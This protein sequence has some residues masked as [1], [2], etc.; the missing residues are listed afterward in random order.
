MTCMSP[1]PAD[2]TPYP[3]KSGT[4]GD[5]RKPRPRALW[6]VVGGV[7]LVLA[8]VVF[9]LGMYFALGPLVHTDGVFDADGRPHHL[10]L[11]AH[12][13]RAI[14]VEPASFVGCDVTDGTGKQVALRHPSGD[15]TY[16]DWAAEQTF[17]TGDGDL[18]FTCSSGTP[19]DDQFGDQFEVR[20]GRI[21]SGAAMVGGI[22]LAIV[23]P[24]VLGLTG[25]V[26]LIV[27]VILFATRPPR[28][29]S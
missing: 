13:R 8:P 28:T 9:G 5:P 11:P 2:P 26:V 16:N 1:P 15:Y 7:L 20:I 23:G 21:P 14:F 19:L 24:L 18:T 6:F 12:E 25:L 17:D 29:K 3:T 4:P 27:T 22:L 10:S